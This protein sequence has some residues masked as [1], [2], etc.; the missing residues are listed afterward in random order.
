[1]R[2]KNLAPAVTTLRWPVL[3]DPVTSRNV[4]G[5][6]RTQIAGSMASM[7]SRSPSHFRK[8]ATMGP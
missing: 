6:G 7:I 2:G 3:A 8:L 4:Q 5:A 1:M